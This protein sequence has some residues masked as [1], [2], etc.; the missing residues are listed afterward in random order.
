MTAILN[1][2]RRSRIPEAVRRTN[3]GSASSAKR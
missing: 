1:A 2:S 3:A